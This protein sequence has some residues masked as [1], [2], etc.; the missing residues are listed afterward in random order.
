MKIIVV[1]DTHGDN[2]DV[3]EKIMELGKPDV[4]IHLGD[5]VEDGI[6]ISK[7]F[8]VETIIVRGNGD[9]GS[10][11]KDDELIELEG[12]KLFITHGHKYNVRNTIANLYYRGL[13]LGADIILFGHTHVPVNVKEDGIIILNPGSPSLPRGINRK[14]T[15]GLIEIEDTINTKIIEIN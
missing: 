5:Y 1:S 13:E 14:K 3:I 7:A 9:Y 11:Y 12:K 15:F 8:G 10:A 4:L 6:K 2:K